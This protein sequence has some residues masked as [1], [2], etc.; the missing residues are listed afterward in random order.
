M[1]YM[2]GV[3][4]PTM[5]INDAWNKRCGPGG[6]TRRLHQQLSLWVERLSFGYAQKEYPSERLIGGETGSTRAV[7]T[8][9]L[10]GMVP[11]LSGQ[12]TSAN[13]NFE[14]LAVAA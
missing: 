8:H 2:S 5:A 9:L 12:I 14:A 6:S 4:Q 1:A 13:D 11:P 7:K 3:G 10:L